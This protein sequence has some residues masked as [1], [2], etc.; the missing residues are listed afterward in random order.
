LWVAVPAEA[1][2]G[3]FACA[4]EGGLVV[5]PAGIASAYPPWYSKAG[6]QGCYD[7][8]RVIDFHL[9]DPALPG[10]S[11]AG[12]SS[13]CQ[14]LPPCILKLLVYLLEAYDGNDRVASGR[15]IGI[16]TGKQ[17]VD[18]LLHFTDR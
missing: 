11:D 12:R 3:Y 9:S 15:I 1:P 17:L 7:C 13:R 10:S 5:S 8:D 4:G 6:R 14:P 2:V 18:K 16:F